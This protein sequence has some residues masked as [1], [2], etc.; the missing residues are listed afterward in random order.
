MLNNAVHH[1]C[2]QEETLPG[3]RCGQVFLHFGYTACYRKGTGHLAKQHS[4]T[5]ISD[6][7]R[8]SGDVACS[9][10]NG[11][12]RPNRNGTEMFKNTRVISPFLTRLNIILVIF[13]S[14]LA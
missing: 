4:P 13:I 5:H 14:L 11:T 2:C 7:K 12:D 3:V 8:Q 10:R 9:N 6:Q 1:R